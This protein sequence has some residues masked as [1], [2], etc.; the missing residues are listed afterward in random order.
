MVVQQC[1]RTL[2]IVLISGSFPERAAPGAFRP[3]RDRQSTFAPDAFT[4][5]PQRWYSS[6]RKAR[7]SAG[8]A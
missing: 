4:I 2:S 8:P 1:A 5:A 3:P 6:F 7:N